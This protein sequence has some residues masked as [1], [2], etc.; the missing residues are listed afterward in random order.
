MLV[1]HRHCSLA[2]NNLFWR[3][4]S[5]TNTT[6]PLNLRKHFCDLVSDEPSIEGLVEVY[7]ITFADNLLYLLQT[8]VRSE[9]TRA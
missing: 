1:N 8:I 6:K 9:N 3:I 2:I 5:E 7:S 4:A